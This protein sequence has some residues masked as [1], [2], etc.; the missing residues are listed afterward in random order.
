MN[1][2]Q[3]KKIIAIFERI[4][5]VLEKMEERYSLGSS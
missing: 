4:A 2:Y 1:T 5:I 3:A